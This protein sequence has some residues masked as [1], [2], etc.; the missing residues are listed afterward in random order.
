[1][2]A[3]E[4][5]KATP[6]CNVYTQYTFLPMQFVLSYHKY[7]EKNRENEDAERKK[8]MKKLVSA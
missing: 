6:G 8:G 2:H 7:L 3:N 5:N 4:T 1:M